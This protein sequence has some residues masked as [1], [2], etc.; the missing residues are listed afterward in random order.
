M[1]RATIHTAL[2]IVFLAC[3]AAAQQSAQKDSVRKP[4]SGVSD[5]GFV[6]QKSPLGAVLRSAVI[7]GFGQF[8]NESYWKLPVILGVTAY[9][10]SGYFDQNSLFATYR[11][12]YAA[13]ISVTQ[14]S[15]ELQWKLYR[16]FYRDQRDT[17][18]WWLVAV[19]FIQIADAFVDA[20]L[21]DF[22]VSDSKH[23]RAYISPAGLSFSIRW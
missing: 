10:L 5:T 22:D 6:M 21:F 3:S 17:F 7:P 16:E 23:A 9:L 15:G 18:A 8:Y 4:Q 12:R 2:L 1:F 11:D 13:S 20:H 14:P 19:Y